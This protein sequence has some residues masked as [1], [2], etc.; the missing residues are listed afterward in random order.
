LG[1]YPVASAQDA[2]LTFDLVGD[3]K[4]EI[5]LT[6]DAFISLFRHDK[7]LLSKPRRLA[8]KQIFEVC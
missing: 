4:A 3:L 5:D 2:K 1:D 7:L 6:D 8:L